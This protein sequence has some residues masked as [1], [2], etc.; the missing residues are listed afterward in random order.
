MTGA[1]VG[2]A[3]GCDVGDWAGGSVANGVERAEGPGVRL[4]IGEAQAASPAADAAAPS[5]RSLR[6]LIGAGCA[7]I[8]PLSAAASRVRVAEADA[9]SHVKRRTAIRKVM[10]AQTAMP[11][12]CGPRSARPA[13]SLTTPRSASFT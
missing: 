1:G 8:G 9:H 4:G 10:T 5:W 13:P 6:R 11:S 12:S 3:V 2:L 7:C